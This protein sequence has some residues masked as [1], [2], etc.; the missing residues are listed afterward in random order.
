M[1]WP[2]SPTDEQWARKLEL[3][4][5]T[6]ESLIAQIIVQ[7]RLWAIEVFFTFI[8][9]LPGPVGVARPISRKKHRRS[10]PHWRILMIGNSHISGGS[11]KGIRNST[12][13]KVLAFKHNRWVPARLFSRPKSSFRI[14]TIQM[15]SARNNLLIFIRRMQTS[16]TYQKLAS[17]V[18]LRYTCYPSE[19]QAAQWATLT[20]GLH[21]QKQLADNLHWCR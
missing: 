9:S 14:F 15:C 18:H 11:V 1:D 17:G 13:V 3:R 4:W 7:W 20:N 6:A 10:K 8:H 21:F 19:F 12:S 16:D 5:F 2:L